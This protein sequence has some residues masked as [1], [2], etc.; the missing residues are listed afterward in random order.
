M[1]LDRLFNNWLTLDYDLHHYK[2]S[3]S[4]NRG[5]DHC[6]SPSSPQS[7]SSGVV[8]AHHIMPHRVVADVWPVVRGIKSWSRENVLSV[9]KKRNV[10]GES[11]T[12]PVF[13]LLTPV[14]DRISNDSPTTSWVASRAQIAFV[15]L[16]HGV[17]VNSSVYVSYRRVRRE[18]HS[19]QAHDEKRLVE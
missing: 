3:L 13:V 17:A 14:L 4:D 15:L 7:L 10:K 8:S 16:E 6:V 18:L 1:L 2:T 5:W 19:R 12:S 11:R 9:L